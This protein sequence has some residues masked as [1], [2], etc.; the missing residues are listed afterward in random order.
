[1]GYGGAL[2]LASPAAPGPVCTTECPTMG[3]EVPV[4]SV[5]SRRASGPTTRS[6]GSNAGLL[7]EI[8]SPHRRPTTFTST[9]FGP[10]QARSCG[11]F[12][13]TSIFRSTAHCSNVS[14]KLPPKSRRSSTAFM[15]TASRISACKPK[16]FV[17]S[18]PATVLASPLIEETFAHRRP[19]QDPFLGPA[20]RS[21]LPF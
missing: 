17:G 21:R 19:R 5:E 16:P 7:R 11:I 20:S 3:L 18:S 14:S 8:V 6:R 10:S 4:A 1:M 2:S 15:T 13:S 9:R 12:T